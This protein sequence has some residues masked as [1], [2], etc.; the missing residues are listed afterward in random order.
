MKTLLLHLSVLYVMT[1]IIISIFY[2]FFLIILLNFSWASPRSKSRL[3][4][5]KHKNALAQGLMGVSVV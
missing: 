1:R 4:S 2:L 5:V 3:G